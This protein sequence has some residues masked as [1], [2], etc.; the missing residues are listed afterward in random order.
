M[1][2]FVL[3]ALLGAA[4]ASTHDINQQATKTIEETGQKLADEIRAMG[5]KAIEDK[6]KSDADDAK[7]HSE[8]VTKN[9]EVKKRS[10]IDLI[11]QQE[12]MIR[13]LDSQLTESMEKSH[14]YI[15]NQKQEMSD[16]LAL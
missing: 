3:L 1:K 16:A 5:K 4:S 13:R 9:K 11:Q 12:T 14:K 2:Y 7:K 6:Q 15:A 10:F 8:K